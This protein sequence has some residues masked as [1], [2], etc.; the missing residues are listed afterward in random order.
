[1]PNLPHLSTPPKIGRIIPFRPPI[2]CG[3]IMKMPPRY[4]C[5]PIVVVFFLISFCYAQI[6]FTQHTICG[7]LVGGCAV[8][9]TDINGDSLVDVVAAGWGANTV[10]WWEN[11]GADSITWTQQIV[12]DNFSGAS[13]VHAADVDGDGDTDIL[14]TAWS[15]NEVVWWE[16][17]GSDSISWTRQHIAH[18]FINGREV[19]AVD[20][21]QDDDMDVLAAG[22]GVGEIALWLNDG[23]IPITWTEQ[24][25][26]S[27]FTGA[28][29]VFPVD[30]DGD[31]LID[32]VGA[33][34]S[35]HRI[36]WWRNDGNTPINWEEYI[37]DSNFYG[38]H[39]VHASDIDGDNDMD[40]VCA[41]YNA[42]A[43]HWW[44]ND[45][46]NPV[47]WEE[48][49]IDNNFTYALG[50]YSTDVNGD[51]HT[52]VVGAA[53][54]GR[55]KLWLN[56]GNYP[57]QW[58]SQDITVSYPGAW[59]VFATDVDG[60]E[61]I[62]ILSCASTANIVTWWE[63]TTSAFVPE[64][65]YSPDDY[66]LVYNYPN[67]FN[68]STVISY[69]LPRLSRVNLRVYNINGKQI[70]ILANGIREAGTHVVPFDGSDLGSGIYFYR[71]MADE[72]EVIGKM[73]LLK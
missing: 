10:T 15:G 22:A 42:S 67:P 40:V 72:Y 25:I 7:T 71:L 5:L 28:R 12:D 51:G 32:V 36:T 11:D 4:S 23:N 52:D 41:G 68:L 46:G 1:M 62:D 66:I 63:N 35:I 44:R 20:I 53:E 30:I 50:V 60:D 2:P 70:T 13:N 64:P 9:A 59:P 43:V 61:D 45:G 57:I 37:I 69:S 56:E 54:S 34:Y 58:T 6:P 49:P 47:Q 33:A 24:T 39:M 38:A 19:F 65:V 21:D 73:V 14:G 16:N 48:L 29:S 26:E 3:V 31:S 17:D 55:V 18:P 27:T 8:Y